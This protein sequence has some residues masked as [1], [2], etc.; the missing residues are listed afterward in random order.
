MTQ[1]KW[2][3]ENPFERPSE[4]AVQMGLGTEPRKQTEDLGGLSPVK[5][6]EKGQEDYEALEV[7]V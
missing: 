4:K 2:Q 1:T 7:R 5:V 3:Q 6:S